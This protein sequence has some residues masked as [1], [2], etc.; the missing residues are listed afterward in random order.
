MYGE[1][2]RKN[3]FVTLSKPVVRLIQELIPFESINV[4]SL[5]SSKDINKYN[6]IQSSVICKYC[7]APFDQ[8]ILLT[9]NVLY[10]KGVL[11]WN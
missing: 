10:V 1:I 2:C 11:N 7:T 8:F 9:Y 4:T 5:V 3:K 6:L